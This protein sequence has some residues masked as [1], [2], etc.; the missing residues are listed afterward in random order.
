MVFTSLH[1]ILTGR[2]F[3]TGST[4]STKLPDK[5]TDIGSSGEPLGP[6]LEHSHNSAS[7]SSKVQLEKTPFTELFD[8]NILIPPFCVG[9]A[10]APS[11]FIEV[12]LPAPSRYLNMQGQSDSNLTY[13]L[14]DIFTLRV[15][16]YFFQFRNNV[17]VISNF[18]QLYIVVLTPLLF[19]LIFFYP[20]LKLIIAT[21][22]FYYSEVMHLKPYGQY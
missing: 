18:E 2:D 21:K 13:R 16:Y 22:K 14:Q 19:N 10:L 4:Q 1:V 7:N 15:I 8:P 17:L 6:L 3:A 12:M 5:S 11:R 9:W 20:N